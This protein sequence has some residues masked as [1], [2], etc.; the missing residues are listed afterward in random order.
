MS[1]EDNVEAEDINEKS[2]ELGGLPVY[3][4]ESIERNISGG[5]DMNTV[6]ENLIQME[7]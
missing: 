2:T 4:I 6:Q 7:Q 1:G 3:G 5:F